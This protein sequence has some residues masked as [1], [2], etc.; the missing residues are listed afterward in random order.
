VSQMGLK[1]NPT[2]GALWQAFGVLETQQENFDVARSLFAEGIKRDPTH[3][4]VSWHHYG[5][6]GELG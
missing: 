4:M 1:A 3:V 2:F 5:H 6:L